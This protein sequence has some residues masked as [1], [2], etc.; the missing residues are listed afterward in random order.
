MRLI[1]L[2]LRVLCLACLWPVTLLNHRHPNRRK[3]KDVYLGEHAKHKHLGRIDYKLKKQD[4]TKSLLIKTEQLLRIEEH[5]FAMR[6][7]FGGQNP[8]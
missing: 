6:P 1:L 2:S 4:S 7:G 5:D 3:N 8:P